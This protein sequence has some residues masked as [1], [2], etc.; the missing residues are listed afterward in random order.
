MSAA[1]RLITSFLISLALTAATPSAVQV[2]NGQISRKPHARYAFVLGRKV[3]DIANQDAAGLVES[4]G[5]LVRVTGSLNAGAITVSRIEVFGPVT[6]TFFIGGLERLSARR[7]ERDRNQSPASRGYVSRQTMALYLANGVSID[8]LLPEGPVLSAERIAAQ[9]HFADQV[10]ITWRV[11]PAP[12]FDYHHGYER[13]EVES[14]RSLP[15]DSKEELPRVVAAHPFG[16]AV[17]DNLLIGAP[18]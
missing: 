17:G 16:F 2:W 4:A 18:A 3:Y 1:L 7:I 12:V 9:H 13:L 5:L 14:I 6:T 15:K 10:A 8:A 11:L